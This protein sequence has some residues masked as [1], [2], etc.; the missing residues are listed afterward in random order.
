VNS[1]N[2]IER[3]PRRRQRAGRAIGVAAI[4][5]VADRID[6][7]IDLL[8]LGQ[9]GLE[10]READDGAAVAGGTA[11]CGGSSRGD[12]PNGLARAWEAPRRPRRPAC[13]RGDWC[14]WVWTSRHPGRA[15]G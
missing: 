11:G 9:Y 1:T 15:R 7:A 5:R 2:E 13:D 12:A 8:T 10:C 3:R 14:D 4:D 6:L